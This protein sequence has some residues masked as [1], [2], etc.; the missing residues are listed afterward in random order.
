LIEEK[1]ASPS[2]V[3]RSWN[4]APR[5]DSKVLRGILDNKDR[6]YGIPLK[7]GDVGSKA[8]FPVVDWKKR[9]NWSGRKRGVW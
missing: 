3:R 9:E 7:G 5:D 6:E 2:Q 1:H 4:P 8:T